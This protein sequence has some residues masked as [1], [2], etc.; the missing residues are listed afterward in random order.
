MLTPPT[1]K[2]GMMCVVFAFRDVEIPEK[3]IFG[4]LRI[5]HGRR[6]KFCFQENEL[7]KK[8]KKTYVMLLSPDVPSEFIHAFYLETNLGRCSY[9][10]THT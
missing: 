6:H 2:I 3:S 9:Y 10:A 5:L 8:K 7:Q 4:F 1:F